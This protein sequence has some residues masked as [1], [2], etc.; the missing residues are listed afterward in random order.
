MRWPTFLPPTEPGSAMSFCIQAQRCPLPAT[1]LQ[2]TSSKH[3]HAESEHRTRAKK[4]INLL[5]SYTFGLVR[6]PTVLQVFFEPDI[7]TKKSKPTNN[8]PS[9]AWLCNWSVS[10]YGMKDGHHPLETACNK[11]DSDEMPPKI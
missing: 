1:A 3:A 2:N 4:H 11:T 9:C 5:V 6:V 8:I 7:L 10:S